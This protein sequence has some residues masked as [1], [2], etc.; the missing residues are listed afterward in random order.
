[1]ALA[2]PG[3]VPVLA[4]ASTKKAAFLR[5]ALAAAALTAGRVLEARVARTVD[6]DGLPP[7]A[8]LATRAMG[9]WE[10]I[11]PKLVARLAPGGFVLVWAGSDAESVMA[12][13]AW[14]RLRVEASRSLPGRE[15]SKVYRLGLLI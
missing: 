12:R 8:V 9:G 6:L 1:M 11:V 15:L 4:E 13:R 5:E 2:R 10:R 7:I 3:L 14:E